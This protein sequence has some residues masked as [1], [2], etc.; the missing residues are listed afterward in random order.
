M[1]RYEVTR[2]GD[3]VTFKDARRV[4][5][6]EI[7]KVYGVRANAR[8]KGC[9]PKRF[10]D[11]SMLGGEWCVALEPYDGGR[12]RVMEIASFVRRYE[13]EF[14]AVPA[15]TK[16]SRRTESR[17]SRLQSIEKKLDLLLEALGVSTS[18]SPEKKESAA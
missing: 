4:Y 9:E 17:G 3:V 1:S 12:G 18:V 11:L 7:G 5:R 16:R 8:L 2:V 13:C 10:T 6:A 15:K 14:E